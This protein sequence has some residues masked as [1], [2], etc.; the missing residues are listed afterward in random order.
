MRQTQ[1]RERWRK[2]DITC[3]RDCWITVIY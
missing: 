2:R 1:S 3:W